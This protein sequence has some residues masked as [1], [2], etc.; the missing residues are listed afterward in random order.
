MKLVGVWAPGR[1]NLIG[2][3]TD[4]SG[5]LV[6][7]AAIQLGLGFAVEA[8]ATTVSLTSDRF[9]RGEEF[10]ADGRGAVVCGWARIAQAV[11]AELDRLGRPPVGLT[12]RIRSTLPAGAGLSSSAAL[13]IGVALALCAVAGFEPEPFELAR[14]C[15]RAETLAVGVPCGILDQAAC[16]LG[17]EGNALLLDCSSLEHRNVP[18]ADGAGFLVIDSGHP[19][20][21]EDS[22]YALRRGELEHA[23]AQAG[24]SSP[25]GLSPRDLVG[26]DLDPRSRRRLRHVVTE[27]RRV[28]EFAT[29]L[30]A[31]DLQA[32]GDLISASHRSLRDDYEVSTPELDA[33]VDLAM[34]LGARG[35]RLVGGGFGGSVLALADTE[36]AGRLRTGLIDAAI[37]LTVVVVDPSRGAFVKG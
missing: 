36:R 7:P 34:R 6:L 14:A 22:H 31:G 24:V 4:Y 25:R 30:E 3:H 15:Q 12:G 32:A 2:E 21:L 20:R 33:V 27:N 17:T 28:L 1:V 8:Q 16:L 37:G 26:L 29:A 13:E 5:G 19:R 35:A 18:I 9:G 11:A 10:A 23:L